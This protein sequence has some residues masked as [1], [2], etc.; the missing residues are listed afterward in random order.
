ML[1]ALG[2]AGAAFASVPNIGVPTSCNGPAST[3]IIEPNTIAPSCDGTLVFGGFAKHPFGHLR[4]HNWTTRGA[5]ATGAA[6]LDNCNPDCVSGTRTPHPATVRLS[7]PRIEG[8]Y[9]IYTRIYVTARGMRPFTQTMGYSR[10]SGG[11]GA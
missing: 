9:E 1:A 11:W 3:L 8:G 10:T 4:W 2:A 7:K 5:V 6:W